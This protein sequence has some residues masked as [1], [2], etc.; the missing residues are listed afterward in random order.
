MLR[1]REYCDH[2]LP[3]AV[4]H[5]LLS[6]KHLW[7][8]QWLYSM[9]RVKYNSSRW[10]KLFHYLLFL[11]SPPKKPQNQKNKTKMK[12]SS[13][14]HTSCSMTAAEIHA[15]IVIQSTSWNAP[16]TRARYPPPNPSVSQTTHHFPCNS[17]PSDT[18]LS[19]T[20]EFCWCCSAENCLGPSGSGPYRNVTNGDE[21]WHLCL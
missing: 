6:S 1:A 17:V 10:T 2:C 13:W 7:L 20:F 11:K 15:V 21:T 12:R 4:K 14:Q 9:V 5:W 16:H 8:Q 18:K 19:A 3:I